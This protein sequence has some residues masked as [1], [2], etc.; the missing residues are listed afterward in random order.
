MTYTKGP[1]QSS[2]DGWIETIR[3]ESIVYYRGCGS[4]TA[5]WASDADYR[6]AMAAPDLL[7]ALIAVVRV[8][9]RATAE[10]DAARASIAKATGETT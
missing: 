5:E 10:F 7:E 3:G 1:W 9:D 4:H 2:G 6:L 8:A